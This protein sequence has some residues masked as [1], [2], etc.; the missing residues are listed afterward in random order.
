MK[1][2]G[3]LMVTVGFIVAALAAVLARDEVNWLLYVPAFAAGAAGVAAIRIENVRHSKTEHHVVARI[4]TV[5]SSLERISANINKLNGE[6]H[7]I[8]TYDVRHRIDELFVDDLGKFADARESIVHRYGLAAYGE[9]MS[10]FA[11]GERYLNRVWS[12]SADGY[13][14]EVNA[15]L[16]RAKEQFTQSHQKVRQLR[17]NTPP[18]V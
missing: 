12:A 4:E 17:E 1:I 6:K 7:S 13:I 11:A 14:D 18:P 9:I 5:E 15:Y 16:D 3:F 2:L 10:S 8:N